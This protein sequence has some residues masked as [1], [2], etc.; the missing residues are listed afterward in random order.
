[1]TR[2]EFRQWT[3]NEII[4]LDGATGSNLI[5]AGMPIGVCPEQWCINNSKVLLDL[6]KAYVNAGTNIL[7]APTFSGNR[8]KLREYG[9]D[10]MA[11]YINRELVKLS[12]EAA[13]TRAKVALDLTMTGRQLEPFGDLTFDELYDVY[14]EQITY[15]VMEGCD[16]IVIETM[17]S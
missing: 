14:K 2:E 15:G 7:Y 1:M 12:K 4:Y 9:L 13:G 3:S 17:M 16:L 6:Q 8:I 5:S 10:S 11:E